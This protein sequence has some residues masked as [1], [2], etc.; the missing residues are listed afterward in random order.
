MKQLR[1]LIFSS[2]LSIILLA[3]GCS[4][5]TQ[6][7]TSPTIPAQ[8]SNTPQTINS[9]QTQAAPTQ[10]TTI[11]PSFEEQRILIIQY[12][13]AFNKIYNDAARSTS[14]I[15]NAPSNLSQSTTDVTL[16]GIGQFM[17]VYEGW[18]N[19]LN[20]LH[21]PEIDEAKTH[22]D[23]FKIILSDSITLFKNLQK[24]VI[25]NNEGA[26]NQ[27]SSSFQALLS[28]ESLFNR[29][30]ESL[31]LKYNIPDYEVNYSQRGK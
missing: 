27:G 1:L 17:I 28:R 25:E 24:A 29:T 30:T 10:K 9:S 23:A 8:T 18:L 6:S 22:L 14:S 16:N 4:S 13:T 15:I 3:T 19:R 7:V 20:E 31:M 26:F 2:I 21:A 5:T 11:K 12:L